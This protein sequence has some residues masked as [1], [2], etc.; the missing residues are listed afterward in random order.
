[1]QFK[2]EYVYMLF[3]VYGSCISCNDSQYS[4]AVFLIDC[5]IEALKSTVCNC[6]QFEKTPLLSILRLDG[7][8]ILLI[9]VLLNAYSPIYDIV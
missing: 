8:V 7:I 4:N 6:L 1:M 9:A 5:N 2:N 3:S